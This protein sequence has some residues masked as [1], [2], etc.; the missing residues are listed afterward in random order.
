MHQVNG[1]EPLAAL[2]FTRRWLLGRSHPTPVARR[3]KRLLARRSPERERVM[4]TLL[5][6]RKKRSFMTDSSYLPE[7]TGGDRGRDFQHNGQ[8][9]GRYVPT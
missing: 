1:C 9:Y 8:V 2:I 6:D 7:T 3:V 5:H 4:D